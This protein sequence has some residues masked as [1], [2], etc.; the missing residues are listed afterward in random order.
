ENACNDLIV[1]KMPFTITTRERAE[2][3]SEIDVV[4]SNLDLIPKSIKTLRIV[5]IKDFDVCPCAGTHIRN[6]EEIG[7][8]KILKKEGKGKD[9]ERVIYTLE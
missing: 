2:L 7:K 3:E 6:I 5:S 9:K 4:R 8:I 1:K